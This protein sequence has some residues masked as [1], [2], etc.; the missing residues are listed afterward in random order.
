MAED[1]I[2]NPQW[3]ALTKVFLSDVGKFL[4]LMQSLII[5]D[6]PTGNIG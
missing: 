3:A 1:Y 6:V 5:E 2:V 4:V